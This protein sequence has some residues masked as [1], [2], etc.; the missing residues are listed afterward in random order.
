[1]PKRRASVAAATAT[2]VIGDSYIPPKRIKD[3]VAILGSASSSC[4]M[5]PFGD[6]SFEIWG[7]GWRPMPRCDRWFEMHLWQVCLDVGPEY[8]RM[9]SETKQPVYMLEV[10]REVPTSVRFP[11]EE[12]T[13][14][15]GPR[16]LGTDKRH[17][18][19]ASSVAYMIAMA[20]TEGFKHI[21]VWG[22]DMLTDGEYQHQRPNCEWLLGIAEGRGIET[23]VPPES[24]L[25]KM[26]FLYG[27]DLEDVK[28][29]ISATDLEKWVNEQ[30]NKMTQQRDQ[31]QGHAVA[32][33]GARQAYDLF[34]AYLDNH[35]RGGVL[36]ASAN[37]MLPS[38]P[39]LPTVPLKQ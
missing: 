32:C 39:T 17:P 30:K 22:V 38:L 34:L 5:A 1:M 3:K 15:F 6:P 12:M 29:S 11:I 7:L 2:A 19:W 20:I 9:L 8:L 25:L 35:K 14:C 36:P 37:P 23:Y 27:Y 24:A 21:E 10:R 13:A 16:L 26:G 18:Y 4:N 33:D 31:H 28:K